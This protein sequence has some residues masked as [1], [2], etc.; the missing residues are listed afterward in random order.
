VIQT[1]ETVKLDYVPAELE[2]CPFCGAQPYWLGV[3]QGA[4]IEPHFYHPG[5]TTDKDCVLSGRGCS[6]DYVEIWNT[7]ATDEAVIEK[8]VSALEPVREGIAASEWHDVNGEQ[9]K[10]LLVAQTAI[11]RIDTALEAARKQG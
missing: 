11:D 1:L 9:M 6:M 7:R 3:R 2:G 4:W 10:R 5:V 8:L